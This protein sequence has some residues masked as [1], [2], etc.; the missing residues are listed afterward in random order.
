[1]AF[2]DNSGDIILDAVL[3]DA[4]RQRM[5]RGEFKIVKFALAD[6]EIDYSLFN[7][8]H[9][10][11]SAFADLVI[12]Q[13][14]ILEAFTN[15]TSVMKTKLVSY[16][17]NNILY[18]PLL[19]LNGK[20]GTASQVISSQF[21]GYFVSADEATD[22]ALT[23]GTITINGTQQPRSFANST[24]AG[25]FPY[26]LSL[27]GDSAKSN[28]I[29]IDQGLDTGGIPSVSENVPSD[30]IETAFLVRID[31]RL[32]RLHGHSQ[33]SPTFGAKTNSFVD[34]DAIA[35]YYIPFSDDTVGQQRTYNSQSD[36]D[37]AGE[38]FNG[39]LGPT[40]SL[41]VKASE[42]VQGS[43]ALFDELGSQGSSTVKPLTHISDPQNY[44][45]IDT[46]MNVVGVT[47]G[48]SIDIPLRI[49]KK[50]S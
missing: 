8:N 29:R 25:F 12:M 32:L 14:P 5:A 20:E 39:P 46:T 19:K 11:G 50:V 1:M 23:A 34:D 26:N 47:T 37:A 28:K 41:M 18:L 44:K 9:P 43:E 35:S 10:S 15:N 40:L 22:E 6:E 17:R 33:S 4:G 30:L 38:T 42:A 45:F 16:N 2:L 49:W 3:T 31:H 13:S 48:Y 24:H 27:R 21:E 36:A 7:P